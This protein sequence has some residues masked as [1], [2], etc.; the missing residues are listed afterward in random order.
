MFG[1]PSRATI[2]THRITALVSTLVWSLFPIALAQEAAVPSGPNIEPVDF[3]ATAVAQAEPSASPSGSAWSHVVCSP[4][5]KRVATVSQP[6][7]DKSKGEVVIWNLA[8]A[9]PVCRFEQAGRVTAVAFS[10][11]GSL[12]ALGPD[13][14]QAGVKLID[15]AKGELRHTLLGPAAKTNCLAWSA[16]GKRLAL[17]STFD[18]TVRLWDVVEK[19]FTKAHE[20]ELGIILAVAFA[21]DGTVLVAGTPQREPDSLAI[22]DASTGKPTQSLKGHKESVEAATFSNDAT[23]LTSAG[24]DATVRLWNLATGEETATL[25]GH[26]RGIRSV[27][28]SNGLRVSLTAMAPKPPTNVT[29]SA[30]RIAEP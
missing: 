11:D 1:K 17:G 16:D 12:L 18:K 2:T 3:A 28:M 27:A 5:G 22:V 4:D 21:K 13:G 19:K 20:V 24:Y 23:V 29:T 25:K 26:K 9:K 15:C 30:L 7:G 8:D 10:P 6:D 14:P